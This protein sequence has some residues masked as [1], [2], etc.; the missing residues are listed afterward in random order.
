MTDRYWDEF[1]TFAIAMG[2]DLDLRRRSRHRHFRLNPVDGVP[3][4][5]AHFAVVASGESPVRPAGNRVQLVLEGRYA[6]H[7][8]A[9]LVRLR[10]RVDAKIPGSEWLVQPAG[11]ASHIEVRKGHHLDSPAAWPEDFEW[12]LRNLLVFRRVLG[13]FV[14]AARRGL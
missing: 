3:V 5:H 10:S 7:Y 11:R 8:L 2:E 9:A 12:L 14:Q 6:E 4:S 1:E 13:P